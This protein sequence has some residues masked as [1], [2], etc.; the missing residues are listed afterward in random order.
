MSKFHDSSSTNEYS[1]Y[2]EDSDVEYPIQKKEEKYNDENEHEE[3]SEEEEEE[4]EEEEREREREREGERKE[5]DTDEENTDEE[6]TNE[7]DDIDDIDEE[8]T[9]KEEFDDSD[10]RSSDNWEDNWE[11]N[12]HLEFIDF[13]NQQEIFWYSNSVEEQECN[14]NSF[15]DLIFS[16][17]GIGSLNDLRRFS[18]M[19]EQNN[20]FVML[21]DSLA[22]GGAYEYHNSD[23]SYYSQRPDGSIVRRDKFG[24]ERIT[25]PEENPRMG[26]R[27]R[28]Y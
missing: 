15:E 19:N 3:E 11:D 16:L 2:H 21:G 27:Y 13:N 1:D 24:R 18:G 25:P 22:S 28:P 23:G 10:D 20:R 12:P 8:E 26:R 7:D 5:E 4:E 6:D 17:N 14:I 9:E